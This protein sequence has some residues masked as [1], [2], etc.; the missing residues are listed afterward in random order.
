MDS[1]MKR[2]TV[3]LDMNHPDFVQAIAVLQDAEV[4]YTEKFAQ[5]LGISYEAASLVMYL[6]SRSRW[7]QKKE[8]EIIHLAQAGLQLPEIVDL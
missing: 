4:E 5:E 1:V 7:T 3:A 2:Q 8:D 6:R